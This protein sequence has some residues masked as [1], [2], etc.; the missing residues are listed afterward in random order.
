MLTLDDLFEVNGSSEVALATF[1]DTSLGSS[2]LM[3]LDDIMIYI[4]FCICR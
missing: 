4:I 3:W 2:S 1:L